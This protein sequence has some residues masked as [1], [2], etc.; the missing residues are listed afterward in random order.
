MDGY[1]SK[2]GYT[3]SIRQR[4]FDLLKENPLPTAKSLSRLLD[5]QY[6]QYFRYLNKLKCEWQSNRMNEQGSKCSIHVE[7]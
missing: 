7:S 6:R 4:V 5:L 2:N 3:G 1:D